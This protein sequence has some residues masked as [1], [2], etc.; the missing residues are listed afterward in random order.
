MTDE[1]VVSI[2]KVPFD[3]TDSF[4]L[5]LPLSAKILKVGNQGTQP[6]LWISFP[7]VKGENILKETKY[8]R[9]LPTGTEVEIWSR[10][11]M[12]H[13]LNT[14]QLDFPN[15]GFFVGHLFEQIMK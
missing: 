12:L 15:G 14:F 11:Q 9:I 8:F 3:V 13:Y 10:Y 5:E 6:M 7:H 1:I 4:S 2:W